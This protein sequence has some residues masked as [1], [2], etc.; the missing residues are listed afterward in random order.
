MKR[1]TWPLVLAFAVS[2]SGGFFANCTGARNQTCCGTTATVST[3]VTYQGSLPA[4]DGGAP[5]EVTLV[6]GGNV[7]VVTFTRDGVEVVESYDTLRR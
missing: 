1:W 2:C 4:P 3:G 5:T 6:V 7:T